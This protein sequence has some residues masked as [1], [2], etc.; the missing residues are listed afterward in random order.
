MKF[1]NFLIAMT[2]NNPSDDELEV[3]EQ[4]EKLSNPD[5]IENRQEYN[6]LRAEVFDVDAD[7]YFDRKEI[8]EILESAKPILP[9]EIQ[10]NLHEDSVMDAICKEAIAN[11]TDYR[12]ACLALGISDAIYT[13]TDQRIAP[14]ALK[15]EFYTNPTEHRLLSIMDNAVGETFDSPAQEDSGTEYDDDDDDDDDYDDYYDAD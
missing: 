9:Q 8:E 14:S 10:E 15:M 6:K 7:E 13:M 11:A 4:L 2:A 12:P 5:S 1:K 3:I